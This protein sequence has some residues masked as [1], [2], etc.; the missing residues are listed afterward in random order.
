VHLVRSPLALSATA[1]LLLS[2]ATCRQPEPA[3]AGTATYAGG[4]PLPPDAVFEVTL[5]DVPRADAPARV[6]G[7]MLTG[8][9]GASPIAFRIPYDPDRID[10][11][12][13]YVLRARLTADRSVLYLTDQ[14][15]PVRI[16]GSKAE[17]AISLI[18]VTITRQLPASFMGT[19]PCGDCAGIHYQIDL[20][21]DSVFYLRV[22]R[23]QTG[24]SAVR[25]DIGRWTL[26]AGDARLMLCGSEEQAFAPF[27]ASVLRKLDAGGRP[28]VSGLAY[29]LRRSSALAP[30]E[31]E[32]P[33]RGLYR[34][35][36]EGALFADCRTGRPVPVSAGGDRP[37]LDAAYRRARGRPG[38]E[39]LV[40]FDGRIVRS[41]ASRASAVSVTRFLG[42]SR[43]ERC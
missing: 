6:I 1:V 13:R 9:P 39:V 27:G 40:R 21:P 2:L 14:P 35:A 32:L 30:L 25:D 43:T 12:H 22:I 38:D 24:D 37:A 7:S 4:L 3:L 34:D 19:L 15:W 36:E 29:D 10:T 11:T 18:P 8:G 20:L 5:L 33:L 42:A 17:A 41:G 26:E 28:I 31:P 23:R 16:R